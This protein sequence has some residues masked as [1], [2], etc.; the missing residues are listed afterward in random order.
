MY[1]LGLENALIKKMQIQNYMDTEFYGEL[2]IREAKVLEK[3]KSLGEHPNLCRFLGC[4]REGDYLTG[5]AFKKFKATLLELTS[6][7]DVDFDTRARIWKDI[8]SGVSYLHDKGFVH[9]RITAES[10]ILDEYG[11]AALYDF[12][13]CHEV[14]VDPGPYKLH[15]ISDWSRAYDANAPKIDSVYADDA[16][17]LDLLHN[18][19]FKEC[20]KVDAGFDHGLF[21]WST[22]ICG[23]TNF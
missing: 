4:V 1:Q 3:I 23:W 7:S 22:H 18:L 6:N 13:A 21:N 15:P 10:V 2:L 12:S 16:Y 8:L 9:N 19:L 11:T 20:P 5:L 17:S 14:G